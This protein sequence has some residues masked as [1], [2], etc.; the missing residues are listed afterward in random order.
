MLKLTKKFALL[1][2]LAL[3]ASLTACSTEPKTDAAITAPDGVAA[4]SLT[5][6]PVAP[7]SAA[8]ATADSVRHAHLHESKGMVHEHAHPAADTAHRGQ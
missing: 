8:R 3:I 5:A 6:A 2:S 7:D 1:A 4:D